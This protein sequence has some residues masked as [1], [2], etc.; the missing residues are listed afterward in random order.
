MKKTFRWLLLSLVMVGCASREPST[1]VPVDLA[2]EEAAIRAADA[3]WLLAVK[4]RDVERTISFWSDDAI[5]M[6]PDSKPIVGKQAIRDYVKGAFAS[7]DF[8]IIWVTE[9]VAVAQA[10]D[11]AYA[12]ASD[13]MTYRGPDRKLVKANMQAVV[14]WQKQKDGSW[15]AA[16]DIWNPTAK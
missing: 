8:S 9:K 13:V 5:I 1:I 11:M 12:T 3:Q 16:V 4:A 7:P 15:K 6:P 14:V 10:G 2:Q